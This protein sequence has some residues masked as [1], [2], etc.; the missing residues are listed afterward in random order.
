[1]ATPADMFP[2]RTPG[3]VRRDTHT[4]EAHMLHAVAVLFAIGGVVAMAT[5]ALWRSLTLA[6]IGALTLAV[7]ALCASLDALR[8]GRE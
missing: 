3:G 4:H 1:M 6:V 2:T 5:G 8:G 7:G